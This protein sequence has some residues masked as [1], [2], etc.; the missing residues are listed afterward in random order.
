MPAWCRPCAKC[1]RSRRSWGCRGFFLSAFWRCCVWRRWCSGRRVACLEGP[2]R[3]V[4]RWAAARPLAVRAASSARRVDSLS[5]QA[6]P[7]P[8]A[9]AAW[10]SGSSGA[11]HTGRAW[12][13]MLLGALACCLARP[14]CLLW[15]SRGSRVSSFWGALVRVVT[16]VV[17]PR[18]FS[19]GFLPRCYKRRQS[20]GF[21]VENGGFW[22]R[23]TTFVTGVLA[24]RFES[25]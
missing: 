16:N 25:C 11:L 5:G 7:P 1:P 17:N 3:G 22:L 21:F 20:N 18:S 12:S 4:C 2:G 13:L 23:L 10:P 6:P 9:A 19:C 24:R 15:A 14:C 8:T